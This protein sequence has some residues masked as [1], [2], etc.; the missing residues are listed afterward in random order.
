MTEN[1]KQQETLS[2]STSTYSDLNSKISENAFT[3]LSKPFYKST[4]FYIYLISIVVL[5]GLLY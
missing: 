2:D 5:V 4:R 3:D 1:L